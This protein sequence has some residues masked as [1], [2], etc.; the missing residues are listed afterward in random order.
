ML[1]QQS[2]DL[3]GNLR[4]LS[5]GIPKI[6]ILASTS[7]ASPCVPDTKG[8]ALSCVQSLRLFPRDAK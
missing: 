2:E 4:H 8:S 6:N 1:V 7:G 5:L 3:K